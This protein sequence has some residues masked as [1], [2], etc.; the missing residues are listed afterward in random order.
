MKKNSTK[1]NPVQVKKTKTVTPKKNVIKVKKTKVIVPKKNDIKLK[2]TKT[3]TPKKNAVQ[4]DKVKTVRSKKKSIET[5]ASKVKKPKKSPIK[6]NKTKSTKVKKNAVQ[7]KATATILVKKRTTKAKKSKPVIVKKNATKTKKTPQSKTSISKQDEKYSWD[8]DAI[9]E[10][11]SLENLYKKWQ[12]AKSR[13]LAAYDQGKFAKSEASFANFLNQDKTLKILNN[14]LI[15]YIFNNLNEDINS[16]QWNGWQQKFIFESNQLSQ[17]LSQFNKDIIKNKAQIQKFLSLPKFHQ[18]QR[19]FDLVF[20]TEPFVL[21]E[22]EERLLSKL[23]ITNGSV[24]EVFETLTRS[25]IKF[26]DAV[27]KSGRKIPIKT[28]ADVAP[29]LQSKDRILRKSAWMSRCDAFYKFRNTLAKT[30]YHAYLKFNTLA[31]VRKHKDYISLTAFNDEI[32]PQFINFIYEQVATFAPIIKKY[33]NLMRKIFK[34]KL[35]LERVYPWDLGINLYEKNSKYTIEQ[36]QKI[37]LASL[38]P[39][40]KEYQT[41]V[42]KAFSERWVSWLPKPGKQ[43]G[44]YSIGNAEGLQKYYISMNFDTTLR[45]VYT[46]VHELGHSMHTWYL[47][48]TQKVY[49]NVSIFYAEISSIANEMLLN[50]YLMDQYQNDDKM[51][52]TILIEMIDNFFATTTR[53]IMFSNFE[54]E[55][56]DKIN[57]GEQ[58]NSEI[59]YEI[60]AKM[61]GKYLGYSSAKVQRLTKSKIG[62]RTLAIILAVPHF[63]SGIFYVYKYAI[64]QVAS[65]IACKRIIN[66]VVNARNNFYNF[67]RSGDSLSPLETIKLLNIDLTKREPW[68]EALS[69]VTGWIKQL[70]KVAKNLKLV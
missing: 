64:G 13:L 29:L 65:V 25:E 38:E 67:L 69:I 39:M 63:Y 56:N 27:T 3:I 53:Q 52:A 40:G 34:T 23:S 11:D 54:Y 60:Y 31:K 10:G 35:K 26:A 46:I 45:S 5:T 7:K 36:A 43:T 49:T 66:G 22:D 62:K 51:K 28:M 32:N 1:K 48:Q 18:Y 58:F 6:L 30:L 44:A 42:Q 37:A 14:R 16:K 9:L 17:E 21:K 33:Q 61:H 24:E 55:A 15:N 12:Q 8:L 57:H 19:E 20:R 47:L 50:Y 70:H 68:Q 59:A 4:A 41:I 2:K